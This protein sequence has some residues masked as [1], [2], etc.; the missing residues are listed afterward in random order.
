MN[1]NGTRDADRETRL[2][3]VLADWLEAAERGTPPEEADYLRRYPEFADELAECFADWKRFPWP[4]RPAARPRSAPELSL[5]ESGVLGDFRIIR[6]VG[7]GGM[8][9]VY[10]AEQVSLGRRVALKVLPFAATMDPRQLQRF[11]NEARAAASLHHEHIVPVHAVGC[12]RAVHF[13]AMQF[14]EG[15][16]LAELI[17]AGA[18]SVSDRSVPSLAL[19]A[20]TETGTVAAASTAAARRDAAYCRRIAE[21]GV[22]A[23]EALEHAHQ[24]GIVHRDV[25]PANLIV[26]GQGKL[27]VTDF[28]LARTVADA[29]LTM[30]GDLVGTLRYMSPEQALARH[31]L[32]DHRTDVYSLG[33]TLYELL[34]GRPAVEGQDRQDILRRIANEE[35]QRPRALDG[36]VPAD[37][38]T[39]V[40]KAL[41][42]NP[43]E[44]Y[45]TA[46]ELADDLRRFVEV[47]PIR[48]RRP[49]LI[50]RVRK[51]CQ[52]HRPLMRAASATMLLV[53]VGLAVSTLLVWRENQQKVKALEAKDAALQRADERYELA[54]QSVDRFYTEVAEDLLGDQPGVQEQHRKYLVLALEFYQQYAQ[55]H[56]DDPQGRYQLALAFGRLGS[57]DRQLNH[58]READENLTK[59][60]QLFEGLLDDHPSN[61]GTRQMLSLSYSKMGLLRQDT[62]RPAEALEFHRKSLALREGLAVDFPHTAGYQTDVPFGCLNLAG[63]LGDMARLDEAEQVYRRGLAV[64]EPESAD[65]AT[66]RSYRWWRAHSYLSLGLLQSR[67]GRPQE[68]QDCL[69]EGVGLGKRLVGDF[70]DAQEYGTLL[71]ELYHKLGLAQKGDKKLGEAEDAFRAALAIRRRQAEQFP[72]TPLYRNRLG[73][74]LHDLAL[75][76]REQGDQA[77]A[78]QLL[79]E[80]IGHQ[81]A[82]LGADEHLA[83]A[84]DCLGKHYDVLADV[85]LALR[86]PREAARVAEE[87]PRVSPDLWRPYLQAAG[88]LTRCAIDVAGLTRLPEAERQALANGYAREIQEMIG[89]AVKRSAPDPRAQNEVAW[90]LACNLGNALHNPARAAELAGEV[91]KRL[92]EDGECWRTLGYARYR[93]GDWQG[94]VDALERA[95]ML[96]GGDGLSWLLLALAHWRWEQGNAQ[97]A[98]FCHGR[99]VACFKEHP[100]K[101]VETRRLL[102]E[103]KRL[104]PEA[105][106]KN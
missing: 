88:H 57:L 41:E 3:E 43:Q 66:V 15:Q 32:M 82:A 12:E 89:G 97:R 34:T 101:D 19:R 105:A 29:G 50:Q 44:R 27:W 58:H 6:E 90:T 54:R 11:H 102:D 103:A 78:R 36:A 68:A 52:R 70:P 83:Y 92:P 17:A 53:V 48:A 1:Q 55:D 65:A 8:G 69:S 37:L 59:A 76:R 87:L 21:W 93:T 13:Y 95:V 98:E 9:I 24:L 28:G 56:G 106:L 18:R 62:G 2:S 46:Q 26:D 91:V 7:R 33:A 22:Q 49:T 81:R 75:L 47:R 86:E 72:G 31:G 60:T 5:L 73:A 100:P 67:T 14:I 35:P 25:K 4:G 80:A 79:E 71:A 94:A 85:L 51:W 38:E 42:K 39:I 96:S 77:Q 74:T 84:R 45:P 63:Q 23:A 16:S 104:R 61:A 20:P 40:L 10:E 64:K 99:A 30:T